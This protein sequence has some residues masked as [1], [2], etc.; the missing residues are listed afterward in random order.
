MK[1]ISKQFLIESIKSLE[2]FLSPEIIARFDRNS[3]LPSKDNP[4]TTLYTEYSGLEIDSYDRIIDAT[5]EFFE[6][7]TNSEI[8]KNNN[9]VFAM[10][11][12][13]NQVISRKINRFSYENL[14]HKFAKLVQEVSPS[15]PKDSHILDVGPGIIPYSSLALALSTEKVSAMDESFLFSSQS[16][17]SMNVLGI[18]HFFD[19][20]T[21]I[22][23]FD[24]VV[25]SCPC[26]AIPYIVQKCKAQNKPYFLLLCDCATYNKNIQI[27]N[28][29]AKKGA[30]TWD[31]I[32]PILDPQITLF[33]DYAFNLGYNAE[34]T[35]RFL[36]KSHFP[37]VKRTKPKIS[38]NK[39][40]FDLNEISIETADLGL[41][42]WTK[43]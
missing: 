1:D 29:F 24:F 13:A 27:L 31:K 32:L 16:L 25:G 17:A 20:N 33:E 21:N 7:L 26:T 11:K 39:L 38:A 22:D 28:D 8:C 23:D 9:I 40:K 34:A 14:G 3:F 5:Y 18:E 41:S 35:K 42:T 12:H 30:F 10:V 19:Q 37:H 15:N 36:T 2:E 6:F 43:E 4:I